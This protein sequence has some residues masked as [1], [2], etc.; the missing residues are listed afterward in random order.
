MSKVATIEMSALGYHKE[1]AFTAPNAMQN[2]HVGL[3][4]QAARLSHHHQESRF[5]VGLPVFP[6]VLL[7]EPQ[8]SDTRPFREAPQ[9]ALSSPLPPPGPAQ[10]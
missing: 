5:L 7:P 10:S 6:S 4:G 9:Y 3:R 8:R 2:D 1:G